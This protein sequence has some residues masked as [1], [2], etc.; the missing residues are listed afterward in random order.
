MGGWI[1]RFNILKRYSPVPRTNNSTLKGQPHELF[2][3]VDGHIAIRMVLKIT[4]GI[5]K[6]NNE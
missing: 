4:H 2:I 5:N 3:Y 6:K 1:R